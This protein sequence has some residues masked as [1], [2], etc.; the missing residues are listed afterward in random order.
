[1][2]SCL[3]S[4]SPPTPSAV[5]CP[6]SL[7]LH[8]QSSQKELRVTLPPPIFSE[9]ATFEI[10][11]EFFAYSTCVLAGILPHIDVQKECQDFV[12]FMQVDDDAAVFLLL[13]GHGNEGK[14]ITLECVYLLR[15]YFKAHQSEFEV[16]A[17]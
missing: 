10:Q 5:S 16:L 9:S 17:P 3:S 2:G 7:V 15:E 4:H 13:D 6:S 8:T 1:M 14:A 12:N 11:G